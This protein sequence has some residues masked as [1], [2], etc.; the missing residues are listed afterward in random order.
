MTA[1]QKNYSEASGKLR[2]NHAN[3]L[4]DDLDRMVSKVRDEWSE[5][6]DPERFFRLV[7]SQKDESKALMDRCKTIMQF[8]QGPQ[9]QAFSNFYQYAETNRDNFNFITDEEGVRFV[10]EL[11]GIFSEAD[12]INDLPIYKKRIDALKR[13]LSEVKRSLEEKIRSAY[14]AVLD[15]LEEY[16]KSVGAPFDKSSFQNMIDAKCV[17][18]NLYALK[19]NA[20]IDSFRRDQLK[21]I[22]ARIPASAGILEDPGVKYS[23]PKKV[24]YVTPKD[25]C[26]AK[27][28]SN[29]E[30]LNA[31]V[32]SIRKSLIEALGDND[33]IRVS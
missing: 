16:A 26:K 24:K 1:I 8:E 32:D 30:E 3:S 12:P 10:N 6:R 9:M 18:D 31:Y 2:M 33:E 28:I 20:E 29:I 21:E 13:K 4:A 14:S 15:E 5:E 17:T 23:R 27:R 25:I 19:S 7:V 22:D 11:N